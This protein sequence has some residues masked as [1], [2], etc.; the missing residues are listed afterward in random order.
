V[1]ADIDA[2]KANPG[3]ESVGWSLAELRKEWNRV[4][5]EVAPWCGENS[6]ESGTSSLHGWQP[7]TKRP[8]RRA[9]T[10]P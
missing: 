10:S 2:K 1:T 3:H 9:S 6:K 7:H 8:S 5:G 4:K